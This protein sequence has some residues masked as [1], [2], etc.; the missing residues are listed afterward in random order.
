MSISMV[1]QV[2]CVSALL[3]VIGCG[4]R[5]GQGMTETERKQAGQGMTEAEACEALKKAG[6]RVEMPREPGGGLWIQ[7][8]P[9]DVPSE[10]WKVIR[11][12]EVDK[13]LSYAKYCRVEELHLDGMSLT[14]EGLVNAGPL[15]DLRV[16][17]LS[18]TDITDKS[19]AHLKGL[20]K[21]EKL[22]LSNDSITDQG[23]AQLKDLPKLQVLGISG[24]KITDAGLNNLKNLTSLNT[25]FLDNTQIT[26]AGL[27]HLRE[28]PT[29]RR[30]QLGG[31]TK[32]T[33]AAIEA[34]EKE[35]DQR[36]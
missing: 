19:L 15:L 6:V 16:A 27:K 21:L 25:L 33:A 24:T 5:V 7:F 12:P 29:L 2:C 23:L 26:D 20:R 31:V 1:R 11:G 32:V 9:E 13:L 17:E 14:D 4:K 30:C 3:C 8:V 10:G 35:L 36:K 28:I 34:F 22:F 18:K